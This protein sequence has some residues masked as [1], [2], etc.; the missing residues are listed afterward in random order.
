MEDPGDIRR[1]NDNSIGV[2][3]I[4]FAAEIALGDPVTIPFFLCLTEFEIFAQFHAVNASFEVCKDKHSGLK[5]VWTSHTVP[6]SPFDEDHEDIRKL[7][8]LMNKTLASV[9]PYVGRE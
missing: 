6:S 9:F 3:T 4:G 7:F 1:G 8:C 2:T 5:E